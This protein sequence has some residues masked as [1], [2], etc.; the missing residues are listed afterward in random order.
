MGVGPLGFSQ[1]TEKANEMVNGYN[2]RLAAALRELEQTL[3]G[4]LAIFCDAYKGMM[5]I[6]SNPEIYGFNNV[7]D[8][9]CGAGHAGGMVMCIACRDPSMHVWWDSYGTTE[10]GDA[11]LADWSWSPLPSHLQIFTPLNLRQ[12]AS[13]SSPH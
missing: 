13:S 4:A 3:P 10:A 2:A 8:A 5:E 6:I 12:L 9:C 1:C 11:Q 7:R